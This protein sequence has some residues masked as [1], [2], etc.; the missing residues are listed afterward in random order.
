MARNISEN[1]GRIYVKE[2]I[3]DQDGKINLIGQDENTSVE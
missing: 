2:L 3:I 1:F